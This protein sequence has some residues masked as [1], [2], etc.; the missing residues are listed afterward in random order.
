MGVRPE[1][2]NGCLCLYSMSDTFDSITAVNDLVRTSD[3]HE[4]AGSLIEDP[5]A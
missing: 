5:D 4:T 1:I 3:Y 2:L